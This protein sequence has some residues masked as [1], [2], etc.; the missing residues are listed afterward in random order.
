MLF[1]IQ[2]ATCKWPLLINS[3]ALVFLNSYY[4]LFASNNLLVKEK[5]IQI[6]ATEGN[7]VANLHFLALLFQ[8]IPPHL[9]PLVVTL[10]VDVN[11]PS[12]DSAV[13]DA[14]ASSVT[15]VRVAGGGRY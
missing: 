5:L 15:A 8:N 13:V 2:T 10:R 9:V 7:G 4:S 14:F 12:S 6:Q 11:H 1:T 3:L